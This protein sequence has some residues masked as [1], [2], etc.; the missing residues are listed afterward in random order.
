[1]AK[2]ISSSLGKITKFGGEN[3][4]LMDRSL[5][6]VNWEEKVCAELTRRRPAPRQAAGGIVGNELFT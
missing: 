1:V 2:E 3:Y 5:F 4:V 6:V